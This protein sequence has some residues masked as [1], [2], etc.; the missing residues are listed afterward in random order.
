LPW[1]ISFYEAEFDSILRDTEG[2]RTILHFSMFVHTTTCP[3]V[4]RR[5]IY[6]PVGKKV[7]YGHTNV[8]RKMIN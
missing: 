6:M 5:Q 2:G 1:V 7:P 3:A 8:F 4:P